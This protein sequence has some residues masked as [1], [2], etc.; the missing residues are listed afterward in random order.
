MDA[1]EEKEFFNIF[2]KLGLSL[3]PPSQSKTEMKGGKSDTSKSTADAADSANSQDD[4]VG[5]E[6]ELVP[7][8]NNG[9]GKDLMR[10]TVEGLQRLWREGRLSSQDKKVLITDV[11]QQAATEEAA[12]VERAYQ[13]LVL[14]SELGWA[15]KGIVEEFASQAALLANSLDCTDKEE[16][17]PEKEEGEYQGDGMNS[18]ADSEETDSSNDDER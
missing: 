6:D 5:Q 11:I 12:L 2:S 3:P 14:E 15:D 10:Q 13:L 1:D 9:K 4:T 17:S 18:Q 8:F 7:D 16:V